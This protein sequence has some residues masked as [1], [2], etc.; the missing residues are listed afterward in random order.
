MAAGMRHCRKWYFT[1]MKVAE[2]VPYYMQQYY[3]RSTLALEGTVAPGMPKPVSC[4][5]GHAGARRTL[6]ANAVRS[7][8]LIFLFLYALITSNPSS[9]DDG[10]PCDFG[11]FGDCTT[12]CGPGTKNRT[13]QCACPPA[14]GYG[15]RCSK[16]KLYQVE[17]CENAL[18]CDTTGKW[19][20]NVI[21]SH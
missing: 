18:P 21:E 12:T 9:V 3:I 13:R 2:H 8:T 6:V 11:D 20:P 15:D 19:P 14:R 10:Y 4:T 1:L 5:P 17:A 7:P 16:F